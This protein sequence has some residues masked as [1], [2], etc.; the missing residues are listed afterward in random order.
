[1]YVGGQGTGGGALHTG[2]HFALRSN[3]VTTVLFDDGVTFTN[4]IDSILLEFNQAHQITLNCIN[5]GRLRESKRIET[6]R[7][8][9]D[10]L[11]CHRYFDVV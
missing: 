2:P 10:L 9:C 6:A 3:P 4:F 5:Y 7:T 1:M 11:T 8:S